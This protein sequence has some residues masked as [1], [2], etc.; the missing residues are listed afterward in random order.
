LWSPILP[1]IPNEDKAI[2]GIPF[3]KNPGT[4]DVSGRVAVIG[5]GA[6]AFDCG[7]TALMRGAKRVE[8]FALENLK[9]MPL[10]MKE[11]K[12]LVKSGIDVNGRVRVDKIHWENGKVKGL[13][14][15]KI[16]L[17]DGKTFS[18]SAIEA[19]RAVRPRGTISTRSSS[20][21]GRGPR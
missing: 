21:S 10:T 19:V 7:L 14:T 11:M 18:L 8:L 20:P 4:F 3:L 13:S 16:R 5:G 9:E 2:L 15:S 12:E 17:K 1:K 6:T